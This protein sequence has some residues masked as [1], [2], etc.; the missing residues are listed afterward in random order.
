MSLAQ[1][2]TCADFFEVSLQLLIPY[3]WKLVADGGFFREENII[4]LEAR[5]TNCMLSGNGKSFF[6][7]A[8]T[9]RANFFMSLRSA[10]DPHRH[11]QA[12]NIAFLP[13]W[14]T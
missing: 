13:C 8:T 6:S 12:T 14:W 3:E 11:R 5:S 9:T 4:V 10:F 7:T 2:Q 1:T